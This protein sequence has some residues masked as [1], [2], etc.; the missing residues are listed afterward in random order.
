MAENPGDPQAR[1]DLALALNAKG[2][3]Q[4]ALDELLTLVAKNRAWNDDAARK[5]LIQF[6]DAWGPADP[7]TAAGR[8]KLSSLLFA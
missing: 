2:D 1:F 4:S 5:Q 6:F 3:R 7:V 8:Q